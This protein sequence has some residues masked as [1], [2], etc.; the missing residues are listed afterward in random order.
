MTIPHAVQMIPLQRTPLVD[1]GIDYRPVA[2]AVAFYLSGKGK[3]T[4]V[5]SELH[6]LIFNGEPKT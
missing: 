4:D 1:H 5:K 2:E 3:L 6:H